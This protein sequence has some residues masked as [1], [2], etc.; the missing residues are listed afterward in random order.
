MRLLEDQHWPQPY[1]VCTAGADVDASALHL[2][3]ELRGVLR[4][5]RNVVAVECQ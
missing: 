5:E 3:D 1:R 4:V 2:T